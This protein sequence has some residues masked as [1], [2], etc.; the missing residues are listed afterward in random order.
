MNVSNIHAARFARGP[1]LSAVTVT[2]FEFDIA[3]GLHSLCAESCMSLRKVQ[4]I[5][6]TSTTAWNLRKM[7]EKASR[8]VLER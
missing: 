4:L 2:I 5:V 1:R 6:R 8:V 3:E 7:L